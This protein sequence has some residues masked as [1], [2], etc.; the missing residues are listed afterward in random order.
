MDLDRQAR[1]QLLKFVC[2]FAWTDLQVQPEER[3]LVMQIA[4]RL[5]L[6]AADVERVRQWLAVPPAADE[7]DPQAIPRAHR[8]FFLAAA[9][10]TVRADG[11]VLGSERDALR[12][13]RDL[14][15]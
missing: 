15:R 2:S 12:V 1:L 4:G 8:E 5:E 9:E 14:L 6:G 11:R 13:F 3:D 10:A 7:I